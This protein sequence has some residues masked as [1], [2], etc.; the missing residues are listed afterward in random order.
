MK[1]PILTYLICILL[2]S[3]NATKNIRIEGVYEKQGKDFLYT[4][5]LNPDG[6]FLLSKKY[7]EVNASCNGDWSKKDDTIILKCAEAE[8]LSEKLSGGYMNQR[9]FRIEIQNENR[10]KFGKVILERK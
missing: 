5:T 7:F 6:T 3:C 9:E 8:S 1:R 2:L 4:L 10:L